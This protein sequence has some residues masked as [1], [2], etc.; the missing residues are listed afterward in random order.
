MPFAVIQLNEV[1]YN[2]GTNLPSV[3]TQNGQAAFLFS[4]TSSVATLIGLSYGKIVKMAFPYT[5]GLGLAG[6]LGV[7]YF[8]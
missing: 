6:W 3:A 5:I 4:L 2:P 8:L 7:I 1:S